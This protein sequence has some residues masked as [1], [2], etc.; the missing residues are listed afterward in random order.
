LSRPAR[1]DELLPPGL[2]DEL[3]ME[4]PREEE[5]AVAEVPI[6][7]LRRWGRAHRRLAEL[8]WS[9]DW[10]ARMSKLAGCRLYLD[11]EGPRLWFGSQGRFDVGS[12]PPKGLRRTGAF[13]VLP[14]PGWHALWRGNPLGGTAML[15]PADENGQLPLQL[16][17]EATAGTSY[18]ITVWFWREERSPASPKSA[19][20][21]VSVEAAAP[22]EPAATRPSE[23][24]ALVQ[25]AFAR[26]AEES[27]AL[28]S[29][30]RVLA[31]RAMRLCDD[32]SA[33]LTVRERAHLDALSELVRAPRPDRDLEAWSSVL[34]SLPPLP[35]AGGLSVE[36]HR[37]F[38][39]DGWVTT[40]FELRS[41]R[42]PRARAL[43]VC[44]YV[45]PNTVVQRLT[46]T[47]EGGIHHLRVAP[48]E[49]FRW[50]LPVE[51]STVELSISALAGWRPCDTGG[52]PDDRLL[53][54]LL[55]ELAVE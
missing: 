9:E 37:G 44:G 14:A 26:A 4:R 46:A 43:V 55:T 19:E 38:W 1:I 39:R 13:V 22:P 16:E 35:L 17:A 51:R 30:L 34:A 47:L 36:H 33:P 50:R 27:R 6:G 11:S 54:W 25:S 2:C 49:S 52:S 8:I 29:R 40:R 20:P 3:W 10:L 48:G 24:H 12:E 5:G 53:A 45:P 7:D 15:L 28:E 32:C 23:L 21:V 42:P 41:P 31:G 18:T